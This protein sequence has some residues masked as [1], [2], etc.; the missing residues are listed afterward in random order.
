METKP[1]EE[2]EGACG[3]AG[4][5]ATREPERG[6]DYVVYTVEEVLVDQA[7]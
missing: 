2:K 5:L 3:G 4:R 6:N 1:V 7:N